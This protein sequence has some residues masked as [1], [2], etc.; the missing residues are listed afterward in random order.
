ML[1]TGD[2]FD[3]ANRAHFFFFRSKQSLDSML[4]KK[5]LSSRKSARTL[6]KCVRL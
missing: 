4:N 3:Q 1:Q 5:N 6:R 2:Y